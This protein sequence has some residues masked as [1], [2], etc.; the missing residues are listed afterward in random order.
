MNSSNNNSN[1][2]NYNIGLI[3]E[4]GTKITTG[5]IRPIGPTFLE[6][7]LDDNLELIEMRAK[8]KCDYNIQLKY[9]KNFILYFEHNEEAVKYI[10]KYLET[11]TNET[12]VCNL[13]KK[14][15]KSSKDKCDM[16]LWCILHLALKHWPI[17]SKE[18]QK[19][20]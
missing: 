1:N 17:R 10:D 18:Y 2:T 11:D 16:Y 14:N 5:A 6:S 7:F 19:R 12:I 4:D 9:I 15:I 13:C 20:F 8:D 3:L